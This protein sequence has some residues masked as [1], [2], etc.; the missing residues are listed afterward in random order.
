MKKIIFLLLL[1]CAAI[2]LHA[3]TGKRL[4]LNNIYQVTID[5]TGVD[6]VSVEKQDYVPIN[7]FA[8]NLG[9]GLPFI[10]NDL[11]ESDFWNVHTGYAFQADVDFRKQFTRKKNIDGYLTKV[12]SLF[13]FSAGVGVSYYNKS[14]G[15]DAFSEEIDGLTDIAGHPYNASL[16]YKNVK[17]Q[18][19]LLYLDIPL[20]L[21]IGK[22]SQTK[23]KAYGK[24]GVKASILLMDKFKGEGTYT[25][26]GYYPEWDIVLDDVSYLGFANDAPC[27]DN[28]E[29]N[30]NTFV[31]WSSV[32]AGFT[33]PLSNSEKDILRNTILRFGIK[34]DYSLMAISKSAADSQFT[35][36]KYKLNQSNLLGGDGSRMNYIG[37]EIGVITRF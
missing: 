24:I 2:T 30:L 17:E 13:A 31:L 3:Q 4:E 8:F 25:S 33:V 1:S 16:S 20:Y 5:T 34:W 6:P 29:Y 18:L 14:A 27:Y 19:S 9:S 37:I 35:G 36:A 26:T 7:A 15:F 10:H 22:P 32:S 23:F 12:P 28:P 11:P 21:E